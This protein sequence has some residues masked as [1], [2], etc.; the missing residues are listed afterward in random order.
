MGVSEQAG[1][2]AIRFSLGRFTTRDEIDEVLQ[3]LGD[4]IG[5]QSKGGDRI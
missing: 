4:I 2:G 3:S 5:D 1:R